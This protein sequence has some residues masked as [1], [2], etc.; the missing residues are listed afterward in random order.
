MRKNHTMITPCMR[1]QAVVDVGA[2]ER[3]PGRQQLEADQRR[4]SAAD[5]EEKGDRH[6]EE[7][8]DALVVGGQQPGA[9]SE[10]RS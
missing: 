10:C 4:R 3:R 7:E 6:E 8:G 2:S 5:E 1:E 9:D